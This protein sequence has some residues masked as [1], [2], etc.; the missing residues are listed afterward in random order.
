MIFWTA[1]LAGALFAWFAIKLGFYDTWTMLF[2]ILI[3]I[4]VAVFLAPVIADFVPSTGEPS[5]TKALI[6]TVTALGTFFILYGL[7]YTFITG[8]FN[9]SFPR[10]FDIL[11]APLLGFLTG[12]LVLSFVA[13]LI[14][15]TPIS[16]KTF[17]KEIGLNRQSQQANIS[18]ICWWCDLV[19]NVVATKDGPQSTEQAINW[20]LKADEKKTQGSAEHAEPNNPPDTNDTQAGTGEVFS[21][22]SAPR[23]TQDLT[24]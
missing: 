7:S 8:Q 13:L 9:V 10:I 4:Y 21:K 23:F 1:I 20:C 2:N 3:S 14:C 5:Y 6:L 24:S 17:A 16:Q 22:Y 12:F 19:H 11:F 18:Y 15:V